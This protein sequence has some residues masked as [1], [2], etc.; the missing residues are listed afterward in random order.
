VPIPRRIVPTQTGPTFNWP[1]RKGYV[2][3]R[4]IPL[5]FPQLLDRRRVDR[6]N[7]EVIAV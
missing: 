1:G 3:G 6:L 5:Q 4:L 2:L 7:A